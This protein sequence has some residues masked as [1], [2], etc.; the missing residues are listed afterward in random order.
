M[1]AAT[2]ARRRCRHSR[3]QILE[4][5]TEV[6][7]GICGLPFWLS[8]EV[9]CWSDL[10]AARRQDLE[11]EG[12]LEIHTCCRAIAIDPRK[13]WVE[14]QQARGYRRFEFDRLLVAVGGRPRRAGLAGAQAPNVF[15]LGGLDDARN[16][17]QR[18]RQQPPRRVVVVGGGYLGVE[19]AEAFFRRGAQVTLLERR[20]TLMGLAPPLGR[21]LA[22]SLTPHLELVCDQEVIGL[23]SLQPGS[24]AGDPVGCARTRDG[25]T[26]E[27]DLF[28]VATGVEP[29][30]E[31]LLEAG[32][33][34]GERGG[35][36]VDQRGETSLSGVFAA[37]DCVELRGHHGRGTR[38]VPLAT[39]AARLGRVVGDNLV[40][41]GS[42]Y[43]GTL[44]TLAVKVFGREVAR[45]GH[46]DGAYVDVETSDRSSYL[47]GSQPLL[48]RLFYDPANQRVLG[49]QAVGPG[50]SHWINLVAAGVEAEWTWMKLE[51]LDCS[52]TPP[53]APLWHPLYLASRNLSAQE[54]QEK[55][56]KK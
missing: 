6:A 31:L 43:H 54:T 24:R 22:D 11:R 17:E 19:M 46:Q 36:L 48:L 20:P 23:Q 51:E 7:V 8:G 56:G 49:A 29:G 45:T 26:Y 21:A 41:G 15:V 5:S 9:P 16:L 40:G 14:V 53:L 27:G 38:Y 42:R 3:I 39:T 28:L 50:A 1:A 32:A 34:A 12:N 30:S 55:A 18:L 52:Y 13:K 35:V 25:H 4:A 47:P 2:R 33:R 10:L 37:G 44:G